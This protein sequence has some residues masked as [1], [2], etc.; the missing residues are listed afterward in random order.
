MIEEVA[1]RLANCG[2]AV[3][4][5]HTDLDKKERES[6]LKEF[7]S[8]STQ[9]IVSTHPLRRGTDV[10]QTPLVINFD[11][12]LNMESYLRRVGCSGHIGTGGITINFVT[13]N[14][15]RSMKVIERYFH[16][17]IAEMPMDI[18]DILLHVH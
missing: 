4:T 10:Q 12:P 7:S 17:Q 5:L 14:D 1:D 2:V 18:G 11:L 3:L 8:G 13:N 9:V 6:V 15:A 16:I